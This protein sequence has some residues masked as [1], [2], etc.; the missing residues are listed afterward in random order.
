MEE[1]YQILFSLQNLHDLK[2]LVEI[3]LACNRITEIGKKK[4]LLLL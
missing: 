4:G 1:F 2:E 3:N